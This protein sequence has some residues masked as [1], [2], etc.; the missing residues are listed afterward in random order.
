MPDRD[1]GGFYLQRC[2]QT[3]MLRL[4]R[5]PLAAEVRVT[6]RVTGRAIFSGRSRRR[7]V[8][9]TARHRTGSA[10]PGLP[11]VGVRGGGARRAHAA[12]ITGR[13]S[14]RARDGRGQDPATLWS[15]A[16][17]SSTGT[18][19]RRQ[20]SAPPTVAIP[21]SARSTAAGTRRTPKPASA[22]RG[23]RCRHSGFSRPRTESRHAGS[24]RSSCSRS[25]LTLFVLALDT[26]ISPRTG[27][28]LGHRVVPGSWPFAPGRGPG[29]GGRTSHGQGIRGWKEPMLSLPFSTMP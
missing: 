22:R 27:R 1:T 10:A 8:P 6:S 9:G 29:R 15:I 5:S 11:G 13:A 26:T 17:R 24:S 3:I 14:P 28:R 2:S 21:P 19:P 4:L 23:Q 18:A 25:Q 16:C 12:W 20:R 7:P